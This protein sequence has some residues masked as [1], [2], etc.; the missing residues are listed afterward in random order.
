LIVFG[1]LRVGLGRTS[2]LVALDTTKL[3]SLGRFSSMS[4]IN[5]GEST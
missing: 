3:G 5:N 1:R 4:S 2:R